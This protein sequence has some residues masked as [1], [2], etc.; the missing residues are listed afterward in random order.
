MQFFP[1]LWIRYSLIV[2]YYKNRIVGN[3]TNDA[4]ISQ[5]W[6]YEAMLL[7]YYNYQIEMNRI[8]KKNSDRRVIYPKRIYVKKNERK[9]FV[10]YLFG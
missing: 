5:P 4:I 10:H 6:S 9:Y 3:L 7:E 1:K 2:N 8:K